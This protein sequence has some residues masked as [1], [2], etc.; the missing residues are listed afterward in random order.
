MG[1]AG[2]DTLV[3]FMVANGLGCIASTSSTACAVGDTGNN[4]K[5]RLYFQ[6]R[7]HV[8]IL[9]PFAFSLWIWQK[10]ERIFVAKKIK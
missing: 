2:G 5:F 7:G 3:G 10:K 1:V 9:V 8:A 4:R 6:Q